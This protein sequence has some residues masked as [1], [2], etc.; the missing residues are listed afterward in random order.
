MFSKVLLA[1]DSSPAS[2]AVVGCGRA[3]HGIGARSCVLLQCYSIDEQVAFPAE[4]R[5]HVEAALA[6]Q[7][8]TLE[9]LGLRTRVVAEAGLAGMLIPLVAER[10]GCGLVVVGSHGHGFASE[11]FLGGT[12]GEVLHHA[13]RPVLM[14]RV[15][16]GASSEQLVCPGLSSG[17]LGHVL[18]PTD[19]SRHAEEA[20]A[21]VRQL[22]SLGAR[23]VTL[24]HVQEQS[25]LGGH[26][27]DRLEEFNRIDRERLE[28]LAA[29]L[30]SLGGPQ[31]DIRLRYG[32]PTQEILA[33]CA[34]GEP[35]VVV[36]GTHGRGFVNELFMGS[37]SHNVARHSRA[38][39]LLIPV[40]G[41]R[42]GVS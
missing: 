18:H 10:E 20:F 29:R 27:A 5:E 8:D 6:G 13:R 42:K 36:M 19:F 25:Y 39:V 30:A 17:L 3:L 16:K 14:L 22:V 23:R 15:E 28:A 21:H 26:L 33:E 34:A 37:V 7:R 2:H 12:A 1:T 4:I 11:I 32:S 35:S 24:L 40:P 31:V 9:S 38:P 41:E